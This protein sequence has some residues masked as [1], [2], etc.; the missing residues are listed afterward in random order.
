MAALFT[1]LGAWNWLILGF[2]L[3]AL[4]LLAPGVFLFWLG[5]AALLVGLLALLLDP[6][7]QAQIL[8]FALFAVAA[9]PLWRRMARGGD[10]EAHAADPFLNRRTDALVGR[11]FTLERPIESGVGT[12]RIDDTVWRVFG[13]DTPAGS[14]VRIVAADGVKLTVAAI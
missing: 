13:P 7:W 8:L 14:R 3:M 1:G 2:L 12:V 5:L 9:V 10:A 11:E 4:E 6:G